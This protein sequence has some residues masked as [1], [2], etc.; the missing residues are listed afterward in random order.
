MIPFIVQESLFPYGKAFSR[1]IGA[2]GAVNF[3]GG[4]GEFAR[5]RPPYQHP[6]ADQICSD[7]IKRRKRSSFD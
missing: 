7:K 3:R 6:P 4:G 1:V 5:S 2:V